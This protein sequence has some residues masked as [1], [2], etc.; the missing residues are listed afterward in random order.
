MMID[1]GIIIAAEKPNTPEVRWLLAERDAYFDRLYGN[2][3][4]QAGPVDIER[5]DLAFFSVRTSSQLV[6]CGALLRRDGYGE[7][8][9]L[10]ISDAHRGRGWGRQ[11]LKAVEDHAR[12]QGHRILRLETGILQP[13][14][15][16][17]YR[18][19]GFTEIGCFG[20]YVPD[21]LSVFL[22]KML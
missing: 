22:E 11:L 20:D 10:Y 13:A 17:L 3:N 8:K 7:L 18:S 5:D 9:R 6:G 16:A 21:P 4:R 14:A 15:I 2:E 19:A 1:D 12:R